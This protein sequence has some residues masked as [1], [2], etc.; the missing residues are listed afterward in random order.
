[1]CKYKSSASPIYMCRCVLYNSQCKSVFCCQWVF[2]VGLS[3]MTSNQSETSINCHQVSL[4][5]L[6]GDTLDVTLLFMPIFG[7]SYKLRCVKDPHCQ[8]Q[9]VCNML[10]VCLENNCNSQKSLIVIIET[11]NK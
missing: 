10:Q 6:F 11:Y 8:V 3:H 5:V 9:Q 2:I 7:Q 1:M 4:H